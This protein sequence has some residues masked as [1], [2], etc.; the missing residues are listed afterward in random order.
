M[1]FVPTIVIQVI[2]YCMRLFLLRLLMLIIWPIKKWI[3]NAKCEFSDYIF[4]M[5]L[6]AIVNRDNNI[7]ILL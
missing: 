6:Y 2:T 7:N 5:Y 4:K 1:W 3:S